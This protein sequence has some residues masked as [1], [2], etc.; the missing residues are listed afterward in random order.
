MATTQDLA[1]C[2]KF[3]YSCPCPQEQ[4]RLL[5]ASERAK[6]RERCI[7]S[8][9]LKCALFVNNI[10]VL[11]MAGREHESKQKRE[12]RLAW[13]RA[14]HLELEA[15][16]EHAG[17]SFVIRNPETLI[18]SSALKQASNACGNVSVAETP[19]RMG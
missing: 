7:I 8:S 19:R 12:R 16:R 13:A 9:L 6:Q 15:S 1:E 18:D 11:V 17:A 3:S 4:E 2:S 14:K 5:A 10:K